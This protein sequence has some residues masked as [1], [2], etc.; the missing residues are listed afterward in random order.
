MRLQKFQLAVAR[1]VPTGTRKPTDAQ[2]DAVNQ[3]CLENRNQ[4]LEAAPPE[5]AALVL[6]P[7]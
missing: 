7:L 6:A 2:L 1:K 4:G 5:P 3:K